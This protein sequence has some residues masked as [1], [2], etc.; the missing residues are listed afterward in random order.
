MPKRK[1]NSIEGKSKEE[2]KRQSTR[3][4]AKPAPAK[5]ETKPKRQQKRVN[6]QAKNANKR[7]KGSK[8]KTEV[9]SLAGC[10]FFGTTIK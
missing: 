6:L 4:S 9:K 5:V 8:G 7:E 1:V 10:L 2:P 3:L